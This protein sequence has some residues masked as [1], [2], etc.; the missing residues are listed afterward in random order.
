MKKTNTQEATEDTVA[1]DENLAEML[2]AWGLLVRRFANTYRLIFVNCKM[3]KGPAELLLYLKLEGDN[4]EPSVIADFMYM[5]RQP[6]TS[7]LDGLQRQG[8]IERKPHPSDRRKILITLSQK[9]ANFAN[10]V[11]SSIRAIEE[12]AMRKLSNDDLARMMSLM[13]RF[14]DAME[15][16]IAS[17]MKTGTGE[18]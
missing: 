18:I 10:G 8:F 11:L 5:P 9:G 6:M 14:S 15:E 4:V 7:M 2:R 1:R 3:A 17:E 12:E 16:S 13:G